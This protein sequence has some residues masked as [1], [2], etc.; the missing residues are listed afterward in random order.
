MAPRPSSL[1]KTPRELELQDPRGDVLADVLGVTLL[2]SALYKRVEGRAPWGLSIPE[3]PR[4]AFYLVARGS[5]LLEL[6]GEKALSLSAGDV[7]FLPHGTAHTLRDSETTPTR[8]VCDGAPRAFGGARHI[9]GTGAP[10]SIIAGF[11]EREAGRVPVLLE[12]MPNAV[13]V[14]P[15]E[16]NVEPWLGATVQL[17]LAESASDGPASA[18]VLQRLADVL[19]VQVLRT[20]TRTRSNA[21]PKGLPALS[22]P[23]IHEALTLLHADVKAR[24]TVASLA[25]RVG[26][27]RSAFAARFTDLV[28][29]P[30]LQYLV[31]WR[32]ARAA[33]LLRDTDDPIADI[34]T[35]IGYD[36]VPS[37]SNAFKR[38][39]GT[40]PGAF[41]RAAQIAPVER[42]ERRGG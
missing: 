31:R 19:F 34:A 42:D 27:S 26:V 41:R 14:S 37:F 10:C 25:K 5:A 3:K 4:A 33:E 8:V 38:W 23:L 12:R 15:A 30:P 24:W 6:K 9:G 21:C 16:S 20:L 1:S 2:R 36:S 32:I 18:L 22:D 13:V 39:K 17:I 11:F 29:E 40:S 7:A 28:G 35:R